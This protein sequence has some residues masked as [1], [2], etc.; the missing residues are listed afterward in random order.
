MYDSDVRSRK[1][2][3]TY[4]CVCACVRR[5]VSAHGLLMYNEVHQNQSVGCSSVY[6]RTSLHDCHSVTL[7]LSLHH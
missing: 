4:V 5:G 2:M 1:C 3:R 7:P 6:A